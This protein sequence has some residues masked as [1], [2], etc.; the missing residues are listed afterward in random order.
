MQTEPPLDESL[1]DSPT[2]PQENA[3]KIKTSRSQ[4]T[5]I[6]SLVVNMN[7]TKETDGSGAGKSPTSQTESDDDCAFQKSCSGDPTQPQKQ[8]ARI[9]AG[10]NTGEPASAEKGADQITG[11]GTGTGT[12]S[13]TGTSEVTGTGTGTA[14]AKNAKTFEFPPAYYNVR[15]QRANALSYVELPTVEG[16]RRKSATCVKIQPGF[17]LKG[18]DRQHLVNNYHIPTLRKIVSASVARKE[19]ELWCVSCNESHSFNNNNPV[20]VILTDQNFSP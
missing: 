8:R 13:G 3:H 1:L 11:T 14:S 16:N 18:D 12:P 7:L 9:H 5:G 2:T 19:D 10:T 6:T 15:K 4:S 17:E 20:V